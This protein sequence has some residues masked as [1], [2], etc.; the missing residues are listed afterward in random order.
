M[1]DS[2]KITKQNVKATVR[3]LVNGSIVAIDVVRRQIPFISFLCVIGLIYISNRFHA[4]KVFRETE[5]TKK[6]IEDLRSEKIEIQT[7]IMFNSRRDQVLNLLAEKGSN[8]TEPKGPPTK[9]SY[10]IKK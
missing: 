6:E 3:G 7:Q 4:E 10:Y 9:I 8:L 5:E 1:S 2:P